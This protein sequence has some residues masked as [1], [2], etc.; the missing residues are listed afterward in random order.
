VAP[1][2]TREESVKLLRLLLTVCLVGPV[3][4][5]AA[6][7]S[8][9][10]P[11]EPRTASSYRYDSTV[12][13]S[14][15]VL[16][17]CEP[18]EEVTYEVQFDRLDLITGTGF[19]VFA[20]GVTDCNGLRCVATYRYQHGN[21]LVRYDIKAFWFGFADDHIGP[22]LCATRDASAGCRPPP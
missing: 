15:F 19:T 17:L 3:L 20:L 11:C 18:M 1:P 4:A 10:T 6:P 12:I 16:R 14:L 8:A 21:E 22:L 7:A 13:F 5:I 9:G 2:P